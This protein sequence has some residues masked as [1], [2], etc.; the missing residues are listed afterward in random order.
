VCLSLP[1]LLEMDQYWGM[2]RKDVFLTS[3]REQYENPRA[4]G[5]LSECVS[6]TVHHPIIGVL[7]GES[8]AKA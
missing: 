7:S 3:D 1:I 4:K 8:E 6:S 2:P 5:L